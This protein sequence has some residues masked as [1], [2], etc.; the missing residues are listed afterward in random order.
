[1]GNYY[2]DYDKKSYTHTAGDVINFA[3][4]EVFCVESDHLISPTTYDFYYSDGDGAKDLLGT[5]AANYEE[6]TW[7]A[8]WAITTTN[9][10]GTTDTDIIKA[11]GQ[12]AIWRT[13]GVLAVGEKSWADDLNTLYNSAADK[14][15]YVNDWLLAE[16]YSDAGKTDGQNYLVQAAPV[17]EP[18]TMLLFGIGL[19][20]LASA[21]MRKKKN[22]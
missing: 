6:V 20:G 12:T 7:I 19:A 1:M 17:P 9:A 22:L 11:I 16:S 10:F 14:S 13:L 4:S 8:N 21:R 15:A 18:A 2:A 5:W 3:S